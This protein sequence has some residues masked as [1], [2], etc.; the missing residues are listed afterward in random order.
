MDVDAAM[1]GCI[2]D[3]LREDKAVSSDDGDVS[4]KVREISFGFCVAKGDGMADRYFQCLSTLMN[5]RGAQCL[6]ASGG[7]RWLCIDRRHFMPGG[8]Q[9]IEA[10]DGEIGGSHE[11]DAHCASERL[12]FSRVK[13]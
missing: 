4:V 10:M 6:A 3:R 5:G 8:D 13:P 12:L 7:S 2:E 9:R 11:D 1:F